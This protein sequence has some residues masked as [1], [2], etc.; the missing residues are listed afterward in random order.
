MCLGER[1]ENVHLEVEMLDVREPQDADVD[2]RLLVLFILVEEARERICGRTG[3]CDD[4]CHAVDI[5]LRA[6]KDV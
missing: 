2:Y 6:L 1:H 3:L 4:L 5:D